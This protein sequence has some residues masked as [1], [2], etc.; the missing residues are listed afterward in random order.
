MGRP[1]MLRGKTVEEKLASAETALRQMRNLAM[2]QKVIS[3]YANTGMG[4][5]QP[6][7]GETLDLKLMMPFSGNLT[8][9]VVYCESIKPNSQGRKQ[10]T[11]RIDAEIANNLYESVSAIVGEGRS[12][13]FKSK[14]ITAGMRVIISSDALITGFW[15]AFEIE[16][17]TKT[18]VV[19]NPQL[20]ISEET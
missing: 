3:E 7:L 15:W 8:N 13:T 1:F 20:S 12:S 5:F 17:N 6:V 16:P 4:G 19:V 18:K 14:E 10:A 11:V 2:P 9:V